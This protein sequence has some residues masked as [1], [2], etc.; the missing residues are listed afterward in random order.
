MLRVERGTQQTVDYVRNIYKYYIEQAVEEA[1][2]A[3]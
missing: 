3:Q 1:G 2:G